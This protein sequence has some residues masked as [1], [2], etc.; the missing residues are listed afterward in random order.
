MYTYPKEM[1]SKNKL[2]K[3]AIEERSSISTADI[4]LMSEKICSLLSE[5][6][7]Y[8]QAK[9]ILFYASFNNEVSTDKM[10][11]RAI[12]DKKIVGLPV[13]NE[14]NKTM[15][16]KQANCLDDLKVKCLG[17]RQPAWELPDIDPARLDLVIIPGCCFDKKGYRLGYGGG[18]YDR[19]LSTL[20][21]KAVKAGLAFESQVLDCLL[22]EY[23]DQKLDILITEKKVYSF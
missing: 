20:D 12:S 13:V 2:R 7:A 3:K 22:V 5:Q 21:N 18:Y 4:E 17:V 15:S 6:N 10:I 8:K 14:E 11:E 9:V 19:F 23:H 16:V 1:K